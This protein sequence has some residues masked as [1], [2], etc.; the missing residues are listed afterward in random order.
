MEPGGA[1]A[2]KIGMSLGCPLFQGTH[3]IW[4]PVELK[5]APEQ[6]DPHKFI[7]ALNALGPQLCASVPLLFLFLT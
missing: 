7:A 4:L 6:V 1:S 2:E 3:S 5:G